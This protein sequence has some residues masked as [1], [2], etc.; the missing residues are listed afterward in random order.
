MV[1]LPP[2]TDGTYSVEALITNANGYSLV[3]NSVFELTVDTAAPTLT[4]S[5][6]LDN[7]SGVAVDSNI[8][9][10]F[11]ENI[12][13]GTGS[14]TLY[15]SI[16]NVVQAFDISSDVTVSGNTITLNPTVNLSNGSS[17][18]VLVDTAAVDDVAGNSYLGISDIT[19]LNFQTSS[20]SVSAATSTITASP[21]SLTA[22]GT[23]TSTITVQLKDT[24]GNN[25]TAS[26]GTI[27][28]AT[29]LGSLGGVTDNQ[30]GTYAAT[31]TSSTTTGTA[32][33]S[34]TL[35][36][37]T[38]TDTAT[39]TMTDGTAPTVTG[40][41]G[42]GGTTTAATSAITVNENQTAVTQLSANESV[43]WS[44]T[45]TDDDAK[46]ALATDGTI[47]FITAPDFEN[48]S[49]NG[50]NNT[51]VVTVTAT[52][53]A[54]NTTTQTLTVTV[55]QVDFPGQTLPQIQDADRD[56]TADT[57][58][59]SGADRD[60]DGIVDS[61]DYDPQGYF[62][63]QADGRIL[64]GGRVSVT[65]PG[66]VT[67]I[68]DGAQIGAFKGTYQW[69]VDAPGTYTMSIDT[70]GM[71]FKSIAQ[72]SAGSMTIA[73]FPGNPVVLGSTQNAASGYLG[74]Y[75]G[76][77]YNPAVAT[78][79]YTTFV[80]AEGD[81]NVFAN[82]IPF[83]GCLQNTVSVAGTTNGIEPNTTTTVDGLLTVTMARAAPVDTVI[84]YAVSGSA[85]SGADFTALSGTVTILAGQTSATIT[86]P[87]LDDNL[88]EGSETVIVTLTSISG[89]SATVLSATPSGSITIGD[90]LVD[91]IRTS[92][93]DVL[94]RDFERTVSA[95]ARNMS[96][97]SRGALSRLHDWKDNAACGDVKPFDVNGTAEASPSGVNTS[98]TFGQ[99]SYDCASGVRT[100]TEGSFTFS[101]SDAHDSQGLLSI[102]V[103]KET[104]SDAKTLNGR[105]FGG[106]A[107]KTTLDGDVMGAG[108]IDGVGVNA[109]LYGARRLESGLFLDYYAAGS[110]GLHRYALSFYAPSAAIDATGKYSY[111]A[112]FAGAAFS[113]EKVYDR[114]TM[115]PRIGFDL[116]YASAGDASVSA[117][118]QAMTDT[119][120]IG[121]ATIR[122]AR[123]FAETVFSFGDNGSQGDE[124][125]DRLI[126]TF[127]IAPRVFCEQSFATTN[128]SC[129]GGASLTFT[130]INPATGS[131]LGITL[132]MEATQ[133]LQRSRIGFSYTKPIFDAEGSAETRMNT[134]LL[135]NATLQQTFGIEF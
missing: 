3:D 80:I 42:S 116:G 26:G 128:T 101:G 1:T 59:S 39:V 135:G 67:M 46:F 99:E 105:F 118:Q 34:G 30:D 19:T 25:L 89:D 130:N 134:D 132:D 84:S 12:V 133:E 66:N 38:I 112:L 96:Q 127:D 9:L 21:T 129:G 18:Y 87:V 62:Y 5:S 91:Q 115:R 122:G 7:A 44:I 52:D 111:G 124:A 45:G 86:V 102:T 75:N 109:G 131:D 121:L 113:G 126:R 51:Y 14:I 58:E 53:L 71:E 61:Q 49:D 10:T 27:V 123:A 83:T 68:H 100:L 15:D 11:S 24:N 47:T 70:S 36:G 85:T 92:L 43:T 95:Q 64:S 48:P 97:I 114:M 33:I 81:A 29:T 107:S 106:Y 90:D 120:S 88:G 76:T 117:S 23:T 37:A 6:P 55:A 93:T 60:G 57:V 73:N 16:G 50:A 40:P 13:A 79:Y 72:S 20:S 41:N 98:G 32:T 63:C 104:Q 110:V 31:L 74:D 4:S 94:Q 103:Q 56:G 8:I 54:G 22:D 28:L 119:G 2:K 35:A 65:G 108:S 125:A 77:P 78:P 82:N 69:F 17:Y